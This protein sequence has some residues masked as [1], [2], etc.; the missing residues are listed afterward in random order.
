[1]SRAGLASPRARLWLRGLSIACFALYVVAQLG[2]I[3]TGWVEFVA[4]QRQ[5]GSGATVLGD[6]GY[7]WTLLEQTTQNWQSE[8]LALGTLI[9]LTAVLIHRGSKHSRDGN[10]E[11]QRRVQAIQRRVQ[12]L[13]RAGA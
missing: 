12:A 8:F 11:V 9:T 1:M 3:V 6:D 2:A 13:R 7:I 5:H 10:D 4:E